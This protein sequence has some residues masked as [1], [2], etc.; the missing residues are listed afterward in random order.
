M[1]WAP[2]GWNSDIMRRSPRHDCLERQQKIEPLSLGIPA[3]ASAGYAAKLKDDGYENVAM[4]DTLTT[5]ELR[6]DYGLKKG[7]LKA[8]ERMRAATRSQP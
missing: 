8:I 1:G 5:E 7:H 4:I 2:L 6:D 3:V